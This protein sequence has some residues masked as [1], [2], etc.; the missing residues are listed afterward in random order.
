MFL[1]NRSGA[2]AL[3]PVAGFWLAV[4]ASVLLFWL[5]IGMLIFG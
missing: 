5:P 4:I 3:S 2:I 1:R